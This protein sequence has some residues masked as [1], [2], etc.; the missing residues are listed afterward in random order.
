MIKSL[1]EGQTVKNIE[2]RYFNPM[3][4]ERLQKRKS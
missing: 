4:D 2:N 1:G 3:T